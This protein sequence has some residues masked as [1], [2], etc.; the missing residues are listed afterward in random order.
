MRISDWSSDVCSSDLASG[1]AGN[2]RR[3]HSRNSDAQIAVD[4]AGHIDAE[5]RLGSAGGKQ[6]RRHR[7]CQS[8]QYL[9]WESLPSK[10]SGFSHFHWSSNSGGRFLKGASS[11]TSCTARSLCS[12]TCALLMAVTPVMSRTS[13]RPL[14]E[15]TQSS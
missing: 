5:L 10:L 4:L 12:D 8:V 15:P 14:S 7:H 3:R 1:R 11:I 6:E 13:A 9:H 2:L